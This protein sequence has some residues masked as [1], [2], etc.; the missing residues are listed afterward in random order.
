MISHILCGAALYRWYRYQA[1]GLIGMRHQIIE[2]SRVDDHIFPIEREG[3]AIQAP[4]SRAIQVF[5]G[6]MIVRTMTGT[7]KARAI[8]A[9][10]DRTPQVNT[11]LIQPNPVRTISI[12][13]DG[14][15]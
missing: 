14:F 13:D 15:R 1:S 11:F 6:H 7:F 12:L 2:R 4:G 10:R 8:I 3:E 5:A 9:K